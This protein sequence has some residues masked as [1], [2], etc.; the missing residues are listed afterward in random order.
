MKQQIYN[1]AL[2]L[3]LSR[4]DELQGE[5]SSITTQRSMLRSYAR[6]HHLNVID[7]YIDDGWSGTNFDR[8]DFQRMIADIEAGKINCVV[9]KDLSRLGRNYIMTGQYTELYFPSHNVRYIAVDDGVD[10]E[11]G[12][13]EIAPFKNIINEWVARDTSRKVKSAF[14]TK[15]AEGAHYGAY[16]PIGYK[17]HPEIK[18]KI[19]PDDETRWIVEKIF[20]L[21]YQGNGG[22]KITKTLI[23]EKVPAPSWINYQRYGTFAHI[24]ANAPESKR[25]AWTIA[26]VKTILKN[27]VYIGNSVHNKQSTISFKNKKKVRKPES[28]WFRVENTHEAIID[29]DVFFRVQ[30]LIKSR[31]RQRKNKETQIFAGLV[32]CADCGW[33]MRFGTNTANKTPYSYYACSFYGQFGKGYCSM[34]YIRYDVLY[35]AVLERLQFWARAV[36]QDEEK[37]LKKI[38]KAGNAQRLQ[39]KKKAETALKKA[40]SRQKEVDRLFLKMYED[41]ASGKITERNFVMLS[42]KYQQ[43]QIELEEQ[44]ASLSE[45][46]QKMEQEMIGAEKW[47][48]PIKE[49]AVP[50]EL[51]ATLLNTMIEKI[52]IHA[53]EIDD[54]GERT[55][56]IEIYYRFIGKID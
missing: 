23:E 8:P 19:I 53:P 29:K 20:S 4:D 37:V 45:E 16:A 50:K 36:Q 17:K 25:Y 2:Y 44:T 48:E 39:M 47:V 35:Q 43:E 6:E 15:F 40:E 1:T 18:G 24:F 49:N 51:T 21:A 9:T 33:S 5:S 32:K 42:S 7:E 12:E 38:Q 52:L 27:E 11:K 41:R 26:Q 54:K 30:E 14:K 31:R 22:A 28:E 46:I 34:H 13:S 10:S 55:Q 56:E 3:R